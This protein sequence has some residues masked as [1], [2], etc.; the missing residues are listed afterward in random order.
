M[1][2]KDLKIYQRG[3][4]AARACYRMT[5]DYPESEKY[6]ITSQI[7]RAALSIPLNI[8]EGYAKQESAMEYNRFLM[9]ARGSVNE[10]QVLIDISYDLKYIGKEQ[11]DKAYDEYEELAK[12]LNVF[13][14]EVKNRK[15]KT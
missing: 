13:T 14:H 5:E 9:M 7:R 12:M 6:G 11:H 15:P 2:Y 3:Y 8:A 4:E 1:S 10:M